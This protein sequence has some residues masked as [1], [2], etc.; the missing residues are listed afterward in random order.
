MLNLLP[1]WRPPLHLTRPGIVVCG[2]LHAHR[3]ASRIITMPPIK[4]SLGNLL[5]KVR[6][7]GPV[8]VDIA[9]VK[10]NSR[11]DREMTIQ[12]L[13]EGYG[14]VVETMKSVRSHLDQQAGRNEQMLELMK[15][16][17][18]VL[19][20]IPESA[21][22]Q[23]RMLGAIQTSLD[24]QN[25]TASH[26]TN[27]IVSLAAASEK[28]GT[29]LQ[30]IN[31]RIE[32][33]GATREALNTGVSNLNNTLGG[34]QES[35]AATRESMHAISEQSRL[36][37]ERM[38]DMYQRSQRTTLMMVIL[39]LAVVLGVLALGLYLL[40]FIN[41]PGNVGVVPAVSSFDPAGILTQGPPLPH[42]R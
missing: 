25:E 9:R 34:V 15:G 23:E 7:R 21:R 28:Q 10:P 35:S 3:Y 31:E 20:T 38:R 22:N 30:G 18:E 1:R 41:Q 39:C 24:R 32:A 42:E 16:I 2:L 14:E 37:D 13:K 4:Q 29:T 12:Q 5:N 19:K 26:L 11:Q 8:E 17:P 27:A 33:E 6:G 36:N 40:W